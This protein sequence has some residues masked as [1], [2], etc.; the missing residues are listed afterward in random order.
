M[1]S[2]T[3]W[4]SV[5]DAL[6]EERQTEEF[7]RAYMARWCPGPAEY[8][9]HL[10]PCD[11]EDHHESECVATARTIARHRLAGKKACIKH[12]CGRRR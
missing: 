4:I 2:T 8:E 10:L 12:G 7:Q 9:G 6:R 3:D 5:S 1:G 11:L